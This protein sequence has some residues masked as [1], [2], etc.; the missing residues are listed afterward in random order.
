MDFSA[1]A[2]DGAAE[3]NIREIACLS[4]VTSLFRLLDL[5]AQRPRRPHT[6][7]G[8]T[9]LPRV[10]DYDVVGLSSANRVARLLQRVVRFSDNA[11]EDRPSL[12]R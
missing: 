12:E 6:T 2:L 5:P 8:R 10:A 3:N 1:A 11:A 9:N 4:R 7:S